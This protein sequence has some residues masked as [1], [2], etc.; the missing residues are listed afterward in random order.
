MQAHYGSVIKSTA[1][2]PFA[3]NVIS[4]LGFQ[5]DALILWS[6]KNT[7]SGSVNDGQ[8]TFGF[9]DGS[10]NY[11]ICGVSEDNVGTTNTDRRHANKGLCF[12][13][14]ARVISAECDVVFSADGLH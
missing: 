11:S 1:A 14:F 7:V 12:L 5:P 10:T 4:G 6:T 8:F 2:E 9:S 3:S 13:D